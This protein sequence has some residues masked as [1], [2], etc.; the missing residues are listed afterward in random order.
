MVYFETRTFFRA[1]L[2]AVDQTLCSYCLSCFSTDFAEPHLPVV[3]QTLYSHFVSY[4]S[5][6]YQQFTMAEAL[7]EYIMRESIKEKEEAAAT[8]PKGSPK[9]PSKAKDKKKETQ[10]GLR[11]LMVTSP[12]LAEA[13]NGYCK[14]L[15]LPAD[16]SVARLL[17]CN[18]DEVCNQQHGFQ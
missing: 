14:S 3:D 2:P 4:F 8:T 13:Y 6:L 5:R 9:S 15:K 18:H 1:R 16:P 7:E 17:E 11:S 12:N 10:G